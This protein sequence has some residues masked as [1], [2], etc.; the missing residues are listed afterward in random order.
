MKW[1]LLERHKWS[2][3]TKEETN[4]LNSPMYINEIEFLVINLTTKKLPGLDGYTGEF[5]QR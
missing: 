2:N 3:L 1:K 4:N 5:Y